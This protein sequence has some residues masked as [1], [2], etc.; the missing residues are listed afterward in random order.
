GP[1][2]GRGRGAQ[3]ARSAG[4]MHVPSALSL[5]ERALPPRGSAPRVGAKN[6]R[7]VPRCPRKSVAGGGGSDH[8][9]RCRLRVVGVAHDSAIIRRLSRPPNA[10]VLCAAVEGR[11]SLPRS[12]AI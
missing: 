11:N 4:R 12:R 10:G 6:T 9:T 3:A 1:A 7:R 5:C 2:G 8:L